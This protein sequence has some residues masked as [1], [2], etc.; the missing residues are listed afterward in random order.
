M[1]IRVKINLEDITKQL[2]MTQEDLK[3][4]KQRSADLIDAAALTQEILQYANALKQDNETVAKASVSA[5]QIFN[6]TYDYPQALDTIATAVEAAEP[7]AYQRI[8]AV[9]KERKGKL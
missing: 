4:L 1:T 2:I 3:T 6:T 5:T 8:E 9:Y 7:G